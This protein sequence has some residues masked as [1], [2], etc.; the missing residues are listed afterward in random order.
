MRFYKLVILA[1]V[2][3]NLTTLYFY[4]NSS[5]PEERHGPPSRKSLVTVLSLTGTAKQQV[6]L[7]E[8]DHF[9][10]KDS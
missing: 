3:V 9:H 5:S 4:W 1:L 8:K 7:L 6:T 2:I 10:V